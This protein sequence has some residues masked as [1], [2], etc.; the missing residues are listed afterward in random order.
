MLGPIWTAT[1]L[2]L[3]GGAA[4]A[5]A[6][7]K[8][9]L[10]RAVAKSEDMLLFVRLAFAGTVVALLPALLLSFVI[11]G[12]LGGAWGERVFGLLGIP[13]SGVPAGL[14]L[15]IALVFALVVVG[16]GAVG[17]VLGKAVV[18]YRRRRART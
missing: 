7:G 17:I 15:G 18:R 11:G 4:L 1:A 5:Y 6:M 8:A 16:G 10:P 12:T 2:G 14:A 9:L 13:L 3:G